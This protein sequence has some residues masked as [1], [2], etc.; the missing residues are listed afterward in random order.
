L[1]GVAVG[2]V[3]AGAGEQAPAVPGEEV[4]EDE[5]GAVHLGF[6]GADAGGHGG[7]GEIGVVEG[8]PAGGAHG[9]FAG[10]FPAEPVGAAGE[11]MDD[12]TGFEGPGQTGEGGEIFVQMLAV[13][14]GEARG[15]GGKDLVIVLGGGHAVSGD[16]IGADGPMRALFIGAG[17]AAADGQAEVVAEIVVG[18]E[19][20]GDAGEFVAG[21]AGSV[22]G[23]ERDEE[24]A[25][26]VRDAL[27][28]GTVGLKPGDGEGQRGVFAGF[29]GDGR[30]GG[31]GPV[32]VHAAGKVEGLLV[33]QGEGGADGEIVGK[34]L[35][36]VGGEADGL[37]V[38]EG[39]AEG[40][41][42]E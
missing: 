11:L 8:L 10:G 17:I 13:G 38:A 9:G 1:A 19:L 18:A 5:A 24:V 16:G 21:V 2:V 31:G 26:E 22:V 35:V 3:Q 42:E 25:L 4:L 27:V 29:P 39:G 36:G 6:V 40:E 23:V 14:I 12:G 34:H 30:G 28:G 7:R 20:D 15:A 32:A 33:G 37:A 41:A